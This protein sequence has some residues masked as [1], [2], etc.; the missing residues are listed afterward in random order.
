MDLESVP[1]M[2]TPDVP[3]E[4]MALLP[5][6]SVSVAIWPIVAVESPGRIIPE[7]PAMAERVLVP[8]TAMAVG[9]VVVGDAVVGDAVVG[10][11]LW[12]NCASLLCAVANGELELA[13]FEAGISDE[14]WAAAG[15]LL[16]GLAT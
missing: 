6:E 9:D 2:K 12:R 5:E 10:V 7:D 14:L 16:A 11:M 4:T 13:V 15:G 8:T 1:A 3:T